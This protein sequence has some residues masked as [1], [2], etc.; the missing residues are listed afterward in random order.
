MREFVVCRWED[1]V[2][3]LPF[4]NKSCLLILEHFYKTQIALKTLRLKD[5]KTF[6][7]ADVINIH[8]VILQEFTTVHSFMLLFFSDSIYEQQ[9]RFLLKVI[10]I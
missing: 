3:Q 6:Q 2:K 7:A 5:V 4:T 10:D 9:G 1:Q 8:S